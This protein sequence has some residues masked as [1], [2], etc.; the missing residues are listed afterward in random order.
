M[1][2][3]SGHAEV[4]GSPIAHSLSP[5]LHQ[6]AYSALGL[7]WSYDRRNVDADQFPAAWRA[8]K[9]SLMGLSATMPLKEA[10]A[11]LAVERDP[12]VEVLG[13]ANTL[14]RS[15]GTWHAANTD[16]WGVT[17]ALTDAGIVPKTATIVG[18]G[19]TA[20]A[21]GYGL[22][23]AGTTEVDVVVRHAGRAAATADI[24][25]SL[26][27]EVR[28]LLRFEDISAH[29]AV[30]ISTLPGG[31]TSDIQPTNELIDT[32]PLFDVAYSPWPTNMAARWLTGGQTVISGLSMLVHQALRQVRF[33]VSGSGDEQLPEEQQVLEAMRAAVALESG[34]TDP[35]T[36]GE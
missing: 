36:V 32:T 1:P 27:L 31:S 16:P 34:S 30:V 23:L 7:D 10:V 13:V 29:S 24:L 33:F 3:A 8:S 28:V 21:V 6:A 15:A 20:R 14:Y 26:G 4:W 5:A 12:V 11:E 2:T 35:D 18:A 22:H 25:R 17:G 19:A 9:D